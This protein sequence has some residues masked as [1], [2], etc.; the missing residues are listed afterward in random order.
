VNGRERFR[1]QPAVLSLQQASDLYIAAERVAAIYHELTEIVL[2]HPE[3]LDQFFS[4]TPWQKAMWFASE[5]RWHGIARV[6]LFLC[7]DGRIRSCEMNSDTP[8][9]EAEAVVLNQLLHPFHPD[10]S[11]PNEGFEERFWQMLV[12]SHEARLIADSPV[13]QSAIR[14]PQSAI[15]QNVA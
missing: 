15:P 10:L 8:S 14:N 5:G 1:L 2:A 13:S 3:L 4:L 9:G 6:D 7:T 12:A 11:N